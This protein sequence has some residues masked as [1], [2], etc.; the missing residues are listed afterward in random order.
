MKYAL[1]AALLLVTGSA[2][3]A[4]FVAEIKGNVITVYSTSKTK[5]KCQLNNAFSYMYKG[6]RITTV[7]NCTVDVV[8]GNHREVCHVTDPVIVDPKIEAPV[9]VV[10][11]TP[12]P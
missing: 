12:K 3:A 5:E 6:D 11:C 9:S 2:Q 10:A 1:L 4:T 8:P 7:Q